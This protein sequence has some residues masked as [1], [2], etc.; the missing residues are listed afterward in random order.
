MNEEFDGN[1]FDEATEAANDGVDTFS[2]QLTRIINAIGS[3]VDHIPDIFAQFGWPLLFTAIVLY[4]V[5]PYVVEM[6]QKVSL[7]VA[8]N[9]VRREVLNNELKRARAMQ[10]LDVYKA[11]R[12]A[13][14]SESGLEDAGD[15]PT[16]ESSDGT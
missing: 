11:N 9:P 6:R 2:D 14:D 12:K 8:N 10:Q 4:L 1:S 13:R 7:S 15:T 5:W 3:I 16:D